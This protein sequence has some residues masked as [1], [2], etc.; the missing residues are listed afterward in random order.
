MN[1]LNLALVL[2]HFQYIYY[3]IPYTYDKIQNNSRR[4]QKYVCRRSFIILSSL[5]C[6]IFPIHLNQI[7]IPIYICSQRSRKE[8]R[9]ESILK[10][11]HSLSLTLKQTNKQKKTIFSHFFGNLV[12]FPVVL[13]SVFVNATI[14]FFIRIELKKKKNEI[15]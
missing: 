13:F 8:I 10:C 4:K 6:I 1:I 12:H 2:Y 3:T 5:Y 15:Y 9:N 14:F 11:P 7:Y